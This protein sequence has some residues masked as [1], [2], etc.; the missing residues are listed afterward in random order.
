MDVHFDAYVGKVLKA[1]K[2]IASFDNVLLD[3]YEVQGQNWTDGFAEV[4]AARKGY[5][6][7]PWLPAIAGYP[8]GSAARPSTA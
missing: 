5:S 4:F 1:L 2:G 7:V 6:I 8:I 3:S